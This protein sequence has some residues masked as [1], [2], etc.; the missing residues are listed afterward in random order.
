MSYVLNR[1]VNT[2]A[3]TTQGER[4]NLTRQQRFCRESV[5]GDLYHNLLKAD[6]PQI[7]TRLNNGVVID[8][9]EACEDFMDMLAE[10]IGDNEPVVR[11]IA[12]DINDLF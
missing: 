9:E 3:T 6:N 4:I 11:N 2:Q 8:W 7:F 1:A 5:Y 12:D 10:S